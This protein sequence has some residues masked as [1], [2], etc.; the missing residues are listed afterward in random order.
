MIEEDIS[1]LSKSPKNSLTISDECMGGE[2][3]VLVPFQAKRAMRK[4]FLWRLNI[5]FLFGLW[6]MCITSLQ[7]QIE[8]LKDK[9]V[10]W[11]TATIIIWI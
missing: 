9:Q 4:F 1:H 6:N 2:V 11:E 5:P 3:V 7:R 8:M 10:A